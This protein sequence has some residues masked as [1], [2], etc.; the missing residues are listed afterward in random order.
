MYKAVGFICIVIGCAG[1]GHSLAAREK[2]R[3]RHLRALSCILFRMQSDISYGKHTMPEICLLLAELNIKCYSDCFRRIYERTVGANGMDFPKVWE[4]ELQKCMEPYPLRE[5]EKRTVTEL[6]K[7]LY[8]R[9]EGGQAGRIGQA[10][11]FL[12]DRCRKA[13]ETCE[14]KSKMI[15][16][17]SILTG[18]L[19]AML[20]L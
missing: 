16:S 12:E 6:A 18:L 15:H 3:V 11:S 17:V 14:N 5:D 7:S 8:F 1:W 20:L 19:L 9:D 4:E 2:E 10:G 13:E